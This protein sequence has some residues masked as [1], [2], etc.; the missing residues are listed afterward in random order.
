MVFRSDNGN[1][2]ISGNYYADG[3]KPVW[4]SGNLNPSE[5][6]RTSGGTISG[7]V[8]ATGT[9]QSGAGNTNTVVG[10]GSV[11]VSNPVGPYIDLK[12][13]PA[14]DFEIRMQQVDGGSVAKL[15]V[16][17]P[18]GM[19]LWG[20]PATGNF[21]LTGMSQG[22][23]VLVSQTGLGKT[24]GGPLKNLKNADMDASP[25]GYSVMTAPGSDTPGG[26]YGYFFKMGR[27]D[28][29]N[30]WTGFFTSHGGTS[31]R[32]FLGYQDAAGNTPRWNEVWTKAMASYLPTTD[33]TEVEFGNYSK[34]IAAKVA[35][36]AFKYFPA[37]GQDALF[38]D[39]TAQ[40]GDGSGAVFL[41]SGAYLYHNT[42]GIYEFG[43]TKDVQLAGTA[44]LRYGG[45]RQPRISVQS[46]APTAEMVVGDLWAW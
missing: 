17:A 42:S 7:N 43:G 29:S 21:V 18:G 35:G 41:G 14:A 16:S 27:R 39:I 15:D 26:G 4:H 6:F 12:I 13:N 28:N 45:G 25:T 10:P 36:S 1:M 38:R 46:N 32:L 20:T 31:N 37:E 19:R 5:L 40:R 30:G 34:G 3:N 22:D 9:F 11:E 8:L 23:A 44:R 33:G 2:G 24:G